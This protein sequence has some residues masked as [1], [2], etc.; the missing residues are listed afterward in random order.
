MWLMGFSL[1]VSQAN[2]SYSL[3]Q[4]IA[5]MME[6]SVSPTTGCFTGCCVDITRD[7]KT[8]KRYLELEEFVA[9]HDS[10]NVCQLYS[11]EVYN[12]YSI[13]YCSIAS[14]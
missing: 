5:K 13:I 3:L 11:C 10:D 1:S 14:V 12:I 7:G 6:D 4:E 2:I 8:E 9:F